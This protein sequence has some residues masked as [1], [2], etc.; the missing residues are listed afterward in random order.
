LWSINGK[1]QWNGYGL[2]KRKGKKNCYYNK[3]SM[4]FYA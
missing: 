2:T 3:W 4:V 1:N